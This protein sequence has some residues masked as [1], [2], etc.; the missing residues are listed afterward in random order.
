MFGKEF[1]EKFSSF[2]S[3]KKPD[4]QEIKEICEMGI[5]G[6]GDDDPEL[7]DPEDP[8]FE[9]E[10]ETID[11][12]VALVRTPS[13]LTRKEVSNN[14]LMVTFNTVKDK[15]DEGSERVTMN[16]FFET[17][18]EKQKAMAVKSNTYYVIIGDY[19]TSEDEDGEW[20]NFNLAEIISGEAAQEIAAGERDIEE[21]SS[22]V[23]EERDVDEFDFDD[24][25]DESDESEEEETQED[26]EEQDESDESEDEDVDDIF[27]VE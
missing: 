23:E 27:S 9:Y 11:Y 8:W 1:E 21:E 5:E 20:D 16:I 18:S 6:V 14:N 25:D 4:E 22:T 10:T 15:E 7:N 12:D 2:S 13:E 19:Y 26:E 24:S 17:D 3:I